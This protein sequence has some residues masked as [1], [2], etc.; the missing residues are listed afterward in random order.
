MDSAAGGD[1]W[2]WGRAAHAGRP[3]THGRP[4]GG[5][6]QTLVAPVFVAALLAQAVRQGID[7]AVLL[8]GLGLSLA[9][10]AKPGLAVSHREAITLV[11]RCLRL[12]PQP[13]LALRLGRQM[14]LTDWGTLALGLLGATT[15]GDALGLC[16]HHPASAGY[17]LDLREGSAPDG[18]VLIAEAFGGESDLQ[19]FLVELTF[20][21]TVQQLRQT[22]QTMCAPAVVELM[23]PAPLRA[24]G[25]TAYF[26]CPVHFGRPQ[27]ALRMHHDW[28]AF[29]L[30]WASSLAHRLALQGLESEQQRWGS[31][32]PLGLAVERT[33]RGLLPEVADLARVAGALNLSERSLRRHL[34]L[35]GLSYRQVLDE[36]RR[37][38]ALALMAGGPRPIAELARA[39]GFSSHRAF[40]R[41]FKRWTGQ[42][43]SRFKGGADTQVVGTPATAPEEQ[44]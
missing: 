3:V 6:A 9:D 37:S 1:G 36:A 22:S 13:D 32:S 17:L 30:P 35:E 14:V 34:A 4:P 12:M 5:R 15:L 10:L 19:P 39:T 24:A 18:L 43:P 11:R 29:R 20:A 2:G 21:A 7:P 31:S 44:D 40:T 27:N 23:H 16:L 28:L 41:A 38:E 42:W 26:G 25:Y 8:R 33:L